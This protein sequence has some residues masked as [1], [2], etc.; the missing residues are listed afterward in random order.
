MRGVIVFFLMLRRPPSSTLF[1]YTT[2]FRSMAA[3]ALG[4][5]AARELLD[6]IGSPLEL[7]AINATHAVTVSG[8]SDAIERLGAEARRRGVAFRALDL[9][10]AFHSAAMDPIRDRLLADLA[11]LASSMPRESLLSTVTGE[12]VRAGQL[13]AEY[14]WHNIR[15]PVR[16]TDATAALVKDG[17]RIFVEIGPNPVLQAY[18]HDALRAADSQGRVLAT[19]SRKQNDDDPFPVLAAQCHVAGCDM[20][21]AARFDGPADLR[22]LPLYPWQRER[23]WFEHT[24][25]N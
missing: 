3:L 16:F 17:F 8:P 23:F 15:S 7:G 1:P 22:G 13:D 18:L 24:V 21:G 11:G 14:W 2:L 6:E 4:N 25:E 12:P 20:T 9:D 5:S 10:F 19:L